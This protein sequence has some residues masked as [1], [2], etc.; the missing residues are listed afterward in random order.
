ML[1][2]ATVGHGSTALWYLTR[3]TGLV[4]LMVLSA[5]VVVGIIASLGWTTERWPRFVSQAV[6][7]NLS[8]FC[9][10]L[11]TVHVATT[12]ADGYVPIGIADAFI[13]FRSPYR[14]LWVGLGALAFDLLLAVAITSG[15]RRW[16]GF[17]AWRIV[18]WLAYLCW[19]MAVFHGL[20]AGSDTRLSVA[21][22][23]NVVCATAVIGALGWRLVV[24]RTLP[25]IWRIAGAMAAAVIVVGLGV[26]ALTGPLRPGWSLR[27]GTSGA[28]LAK[29]G[30]IGTSG[31]ATKGG[32]ATGGLPSTAGSSPASIPGRAPQTPFSSP[33]NGTF[34]TSAPGTAGQVTVTI[35]LQLQLDDVPLDV[36]LVGMPVS[37]GVSMDSSEVTLGT[38]RGEVTGLD[39]PL[40]SA[41]VTG[42]TGQV[43]LTL[44]LN[45]DRRAGSVTGTVTGTAGGGPDQGEGR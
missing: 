4:A 2:I 33:I 37:G 17:R 40:V 5:T 15:L 1:V 44:E 39:G 32:A 43:H 35:S 41:T 13:P 42:P 19:P 34:V 21:L 26:F 9:L 24:G 7:R 16:I 28:L 23:I 18:H 45:L 20:G 29:I 25:E 6:H 38:D 14:P 27:A 22:V 36:T 3:S 30:A 10:A 31:A 11:I 12:V 8:L